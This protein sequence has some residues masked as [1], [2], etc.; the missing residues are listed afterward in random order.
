MAEQSQFVNL[1][2]T[3]GEEVTGMTTTI[4]AQGIAKIIKPFE[5]DSHQFKE[6]IKGIEKYA[7]LTRVPNDQ[8]KMIAYQSSKGAV[9]DFLQRYLT[10]HLGHTWRQVKEEL[11]SKF[12]E[13]TDSQHALMLLRKVRQ[14]PGE[15][16][17]VHAE[18]LLALSEDAFDGQAAD[19]YDRQMIGFFIDGLFHDYMK[20]KIMRDNPRTLQDAITVANN[21]Q[22][23]RRRFD[24]RSGNHP[25]RGAD[26]ANFGAEPM[27]VVHV[28]PQMRCHFCHRQGHKIK[29]CRARQKQVNTVGVQAQQ[30]P[31][32]ICWRCNKVGHIAKRCRT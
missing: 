8:V 16:V 9:S 22:N 20:M 24:L 28:R 32:I 27:E 15:N 6:W 13:V 26:H 23:L 17:Q 10:E 21:E 18:R 11:T 2:R 31:P 25:Q 3:I 5:G 7:Y 12:A 4:G 29:D 30:N 19:R 14:K 1:M